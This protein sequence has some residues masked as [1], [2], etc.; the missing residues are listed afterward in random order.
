MVSAVLVVALAWPDA[1]SRLIALS[2]EPPHAPPFP[3]ILEHR[4]EQSFN[5]TATQTLAATQLIQ[6]QGLSS[7]HAG[8]GMFYALLEEGI[9]SP[10]AESVRLLGFSAE[11]GEVSTNFSLPL[12]ASQTG[13]VGAG[14]CVA[15]DE[16]ADEAVLIGRD[17]VGASG[18]A[19]RV[20]RTHLSSGVTAPVGDALPVAAN[21]DILMASCAL[22][23]AADTLWAVLPNNDPSGTMTLFGID[24]SSGRVRHRLS[25]FSQV[26]GPAAFA[27]DQARKRVVGIGLAV[28]LTTHAIADTYVFALDSAAGTLRTL[29]SSVLPPSTLAV[30]GG[31]ATVDA[32]GGSF[33]FECVV[34]G[35]ASAVS[36]EASAPSDVEPPMVRSPGA[37]GTL[38]LRARPKRPV[39]VG[40]V[41]RNAMALTG[42]CAVDAAT[43]EFRRARGVCPKMA[44]CPW[45]LQFWN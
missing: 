24:A 8:R 41:E 15:I 10:H 43:G 28:N 11:T 38:M 7:F 2:N 40:V 36:V 16:R 19:V 12:V 5:V 14:Q 17:G 22:D 31:V 13:F 44:D 42:L 1:A 37:A 4:S 27:Y 33:L 25:A 29:R 21:V 30:L 23:V 26:S 18:G 20:W 32:R 35:N 3:M 39:Q 9:L 6:A 45:N 34:P